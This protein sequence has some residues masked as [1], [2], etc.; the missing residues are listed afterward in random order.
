MVNTMVLVL[1]FVASAL[2]AAT[3]VADHPALHLLFS[4]NQTAV[5]TKRSGASGKLVVSDA[6]PVQLK[7][8]HFEVT[9]I[10]SN[11]TKESVELP[12]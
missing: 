7:R 2:C 9:E 5:L 8:S 11:V 4:E 12:R 3:S 6:P 1:A 10:L